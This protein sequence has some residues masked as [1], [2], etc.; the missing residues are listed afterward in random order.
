MT[1]NR[2]LT[3]LV[4][5]LA[6]AVVF[7]GGLMASN[8]GFKLNRALLATGAGS[9]SG[10]QTLALPYNRQVGIDNASDLFADI[11]SAGTIQNLQAYDTATDTYVLYQFGSPDFALTAGQGVLVKMGTNTNYIVVGSHDPAATVQLEAAGPA[12]ASGTNLFA[13]PYHATASKVSELFREL[14]T[15][16][17]QNI[18]AYQTA[19]DTFQLYQFG[20]FDYD[21]KPGEAYFV[22]MGTTL[23]YSPSHY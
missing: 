17:V 22:K 9:N 23:P 5:V 21:I 1:K 3:V 10:T 19:T 18:Q 16:N 7:T 6:V 12:S 15:S 2:S 8:M 11:N 13:P 14:G 4:V 20:S